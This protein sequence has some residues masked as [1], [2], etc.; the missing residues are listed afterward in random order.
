[1][2]DYLIGIKGHRKP[3]WVFC[4]IVFGVVCLFEVINIFMSLF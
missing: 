1:M 3:L 2:I 4:V